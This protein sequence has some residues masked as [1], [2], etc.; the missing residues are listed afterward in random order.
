MQILNS[1]RVSIHPT[2]WRRFACRQQNVQKIIKWWFVF[3]V[4]LCQRKLLALQYLRDDASRKQ[5]SLVDTGK[6]VKQG[7]SCCQKLRVY[8]T[9]RKIHSHLTR[10]CANC[11][12]KDKKVSVPAVSTVS[13]WFFSLKKVIKSTV[14][15]TEAGGATHLLSVS[16][17]SFF[18][19]FFVCFL[20]K[21][22]L[23]LMLLVV[24]VYLLL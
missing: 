2:W 5:K 24:K 7:V 4:S 14:C 9:E 12:F 6:Y 19:P 16:N 3:V 18:A 23:F 22:T 11:I 10:M 8:Q 21:N 13:F 17:C 15:T 1:I 20:L